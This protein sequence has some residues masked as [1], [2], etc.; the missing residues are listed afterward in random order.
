MI[1][2]V[3][4]PIEQTVLVQILKIS[5]ET[6]GKYTTV[7][8]RLLWL[9][10]IPQILLLI[11][12]WLFADNMAKMGGGTHTGIRTLVA[13]A[14]YITIIF[15]GWYG[16]YI[17]PIFAA[18]WQLILGLAL[19]TFVA[20]RFIQPARAKEFMTAGRV[21]GEK[22]GEKA[23]IRKALEHELESTK[24]MEREVQQMPVRSQ[25]GQASKDMQLVQIRARR[26]QI[27]QEL[28]DL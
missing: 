3:L 13:I 14:A 19:I 24:R 9:I 7:Q 28:A 2:M 26:A 17:V 12:I 6:L 23:K 5:S 22:S 1:G 25:E 8:D 20:A 15:T 11:F 16:M 18:I 27:E 10:F 4:S 21:L